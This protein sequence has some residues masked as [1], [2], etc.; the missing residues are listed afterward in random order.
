MYKNKMAVTLQRQ[1]GKCAQL[2]VCG[3]KSISEPKAVV[4]CKS[5]HRIILMKSECSCIFLK[6]EVTR[7]R[8]FCEL[9]S[10]FPTILTEE[11]GL[12]PL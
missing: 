11:V 6:F 12:L 1:L 8:M 2:Y 5:S 9:S 4:E 10:M 7:I 3:V